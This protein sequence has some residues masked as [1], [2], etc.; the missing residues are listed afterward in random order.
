MYQYNKDDF[1]NK[2]SREPA[3]ERYY[4]F[5]KPASDHSGKEKDIYHYDIENSLNDKEQAAPDAVKEIYE[6]IESCIF[7]VVLILVVFI[8]LFRTATVSGISMNPTLYENERL[9]LQKIGYTDPE[10]GDIVVVDRT[11]TNNP[12][13]IKR[14]IGKEGDTIDIDFNAGI[15]YRNGTALEEPYV[16]EPTFKEETV[17]FPVTIPENAIFVMGD[18]RNHSLDSRSDEVGMVD[19]RRVMGKV[20][21]RF[22]P[23]SR[24]G[25]F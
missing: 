23:F 8:F 3:D 22:F 24:A 2:N 4:S 17:E 14:V 21:F 6:W 1:E 9:L 12:P 20:I 13:I 18:N 25:G 15:V 11:N 16:N 10:Y 7:A 5:D 19:L